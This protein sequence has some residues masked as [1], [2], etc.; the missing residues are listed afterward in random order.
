MQRRGNDLSDLEISEELVAQRLLVLPL[1][2]AAAAVLAIVLPPGKERAT[3]D[4]HQY[5]SGQIYID[6]RNLCG[7][8]EPTVRAQ[9]RTHIHG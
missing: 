1:H 6:V 7:T 4:D 3:A 5:S 8:G 9:Q 2:T